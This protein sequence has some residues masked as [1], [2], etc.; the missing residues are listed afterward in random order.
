MKR[1]Q[2]SG[3]EKLQIVLEGL[4]GAVPLGELC[5][6]HQ[7]NQGQYYQWRDRLL[8]NGPKVFD[9]GGPE[10]ERERLVQ[11]KAR[12][13]RIIGQLTVELKKSDEEYV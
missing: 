5:A 11:E 12:L 7:I 8:K 1:R 6:Q 3:Q 9:H 13:Q 10:K 2:W 4:K